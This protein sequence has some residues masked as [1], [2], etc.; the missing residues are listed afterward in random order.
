MPNLASVTNYF[1]TPFE[2]SVAMTLSGNIA[3]GATT[4]GVSNM[5]NYSDG[6]IVV[7]TVD[8]GNS[9]KQVFT[10]TKSG[11]NVVNVVWTLGT[12]VA[13]VAG[14]S[15]I[16][17]VS[18]TTVGMISAGIQIQH[19][20]TGTHK[21]ITTDTI[22][23]SGNASV[24]GALGVTGATTLSTVHAT[25]AS[26]LDGAIGGAGYDVKTQKNSYKFSVGLSNAQ[27][28]T[29]GYSKMLLNSEFYDTGSNFDNAT[30]YRFVAPINGFYHFSFAVTST[31]TAP[32]T[33]WQAVLYKNGSAVRYGSWGADAT[34]F[35][36]SVGSGDVQLVATDYIELFL[37]ANGATPVAATTF[38]TFLDGHLISAT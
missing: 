4:V 21:G 10:G 5:S 36:E 8:G 17:Y 31:G 1:P 37:G 9:S 11:S 14:A 30:N 22:T 15:V 2:N 7:F 27:N 19:T 12:N 25:G 33:S 16:D 38:G 32:T 23:T 34:Q 18:S 6:E 26:T 29:N 20:Q 28:S 13:H 24:G 35:V 3:P